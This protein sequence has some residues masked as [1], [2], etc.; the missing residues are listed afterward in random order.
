MIARNL[1]EINFIAHNRIPAIFFSGLTTGAV[2]TLAALGFTIID[3]ASR[4]AN[5]AQGEFVM[6]GGVVTSFAHAAGTPLPLAT[7]LAIFIATARISAPPCKPV[8]ASADSG[9]LRRC[10]SSQ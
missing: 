4:V 7:L 6:Q 9:G 8:A 3:N 1:R 5:F 10:K 2:C